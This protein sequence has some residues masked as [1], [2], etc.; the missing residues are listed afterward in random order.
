GTVEA[1]SS[2]LLYRFASFVLPF[3]LGFLVFLRERRKVV[4]D[5]IEE[6]SEP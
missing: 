1:V 2:L 4:T 5:G 6:I 3:L